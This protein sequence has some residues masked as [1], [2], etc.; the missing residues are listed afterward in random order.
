MVQRRCCCCAFTAALASA[1]SDSRMDVG[2]TKKRLAGRSDE[3]FHFSIASGLEADLGRRRGGG[4]VT[5]DDAEFLS[6][7]S[8]SG[9]VDKDEAVVAE[10]STRGAADFS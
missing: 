7:W 2:S 10:V 4:M 6:S 5:W 8:S 3:Q 1:N 9:D